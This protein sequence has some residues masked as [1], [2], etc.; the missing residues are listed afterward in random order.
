M[1][2]WLNLHDKWQNDDVTFVYALFT[3]MIFRS[4]YFYD[5][6]TV[7][8]VRLIQLCAKTVVYYNIL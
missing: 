4:M 1:Q 8:I 7:I 6:N 3:A 5:N 2:L